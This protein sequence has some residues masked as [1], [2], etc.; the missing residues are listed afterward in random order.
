MSTPNT[1][2][3]Q[4]IDPGATLGFDVLA[5]SPFA[6]FEGRRAALSAIARSASTLS[7]DSVCLTNRA[8]D[9][10]PAHRGGFRRRHGHDTRAR[11]LR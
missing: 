11:R 4:Q 3:T 1:A 7:V 8:S 2:P 6:G 5:A 10:N 9:G